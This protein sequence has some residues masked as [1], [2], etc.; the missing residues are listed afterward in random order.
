MKYKIF[1]PIT[2]QS[3]LFQSPILISD[4][5]QANH[6]QNDLQV[7]KVELGLQL[8]LFPAYINLK[9]DHLLKN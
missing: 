3:Q 9:L 8:Q 4:T 2:S 5:E 1:N 6:N 7:G